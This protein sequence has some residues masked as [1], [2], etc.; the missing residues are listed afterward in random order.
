M[1]ILRK[2]IF[3]TRLASVTAP[4]L[5]SLQRE[6][7][8]STRRKPT[9]ALSRDAR[10]RGPLVQARRGQVRKLQGP[11]QMPAR[12]RSGPQ[13]RKGEEVTPPSCRQ[14]GK[15]SQPP[16]DAQETP[17]S[18]KGARL[19]RTRPWRSR[20]TGAEGGQ[21]GRRVVALDTLPQVRV[22]FLLSAFSFWWLG[23]Y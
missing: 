1:G 17:R 4:L 15:P 11:L 21:D 16:T 3:A 20:G 22:T 18:G 19:R 23:P 8:R 9:D 2:N 10:Q 12:R 6:E 7:A 14:R 5:F 13:R